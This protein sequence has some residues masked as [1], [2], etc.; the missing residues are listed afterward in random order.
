MS[1]TKSPKQK[2]KKVVVSGYVTESQFNKIAM[3]AIKNRQSLSKEIGELIG[4]GL[5]AKKGDRADDTI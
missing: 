5:S 3:S 4:K 1:R 2:D